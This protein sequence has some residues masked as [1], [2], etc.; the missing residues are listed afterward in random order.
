MKKIW[1]GLIA[2]LA[3]T[4]LVVGAATFRSGD[5]FT[6]GRSE[7]VSSDLYAAGGTVTLHGSVQG[8]AVLAGGMISTTGSTTQDLLVAGGNLMLAGSVGDDVRAA[9]GNI[10]LSGNV[11]NDAIVVGGQV[12][13]QPDV[14][15]GG[16]AVLT[17]GTLTVD[18]QVNGKAILSGGDIVIRGQIN[19]PVEIQAGSVTIAQSAVIRGNLT[20][21]SPQQAKIESGA[22]ILG[23]TNYTPV[24]RPG[25]SSYILPALYSFV[26]LF[27]TAL[28]LGLVLKRLSYLTVSHA[29]T[30][31]WWSVLRGFIFMIVTPVVAIILFI[32]V[33]GI[34][35]G[36][37]TLMLY[38]VLLMLSYLLSPIIA[39][40][41]LNKWIFKQPEYDVTWQTIL[42]GTA[43]VI[44]LSYIPIIGW[45]A[46]FILMLM[47]LGSFYNNG[48]DWL[49][50]RSVG[51][52][53]V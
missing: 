50:R 48:K 19:G 15:I 27:L 49:M 26:T 11:G 5:M 14:T 22:Q 4:P 44:I 8:D 16:D 18:G 9:G 21:K 39:G 2:L 6:L 28:L 38:V 17:A 24:A 52:V 25:P 34:P 29:R 10:T 40:A 42:I 41:L 13:I 35:L 51:T 46:N 23:A 7:T 3:L 33:V 1:I 47:V 12:S 32:T 45:L 53:A 36:I 30:D 31:F 43:A 20:Y 37:I